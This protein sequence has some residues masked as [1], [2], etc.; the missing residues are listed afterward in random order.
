MRDTLI[1]N[2]FSFWYGEGHISLC[3]SLWHFI[4]KSFHK[5][6][7]GFKT[8]NGRTVRLCLFFWK[9]TTVVVHFARASPW[10]F[11]IPITKPFLD[12]VHLLLKWWSKAIHLS[13]KN[14][15]IINPI[16]NQCFVHIEESCF[17]LEHFCTHCQVC[18][19]TLHSH[20]T[21]C[22]AIFSRCLYH[23]NWNT[24]AEH[25][26][27]VEQRPSFEWR[28]LIC[29]TCKQSSCQ[30]GGC[31]GGGVMKWGGKLRILSFTKEST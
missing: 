18:L 10:L 4:K 2:N 19:L 8:R 30:V 23:E 6:V 14:L 12:F 11:T 16:Y 24:S 1:C 9:T 17:H 22:K 5:F 26:D 27:L 20:P 28:V 7:K 13:S 25:L 31:L 15:K 21:H 29:Q 3:I